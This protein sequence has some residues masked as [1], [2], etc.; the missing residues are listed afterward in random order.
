MGAEWTRSGKKVKEEEKDWNIVLLRKTRWRK[1]GEEE[2]GVMLLNSG[3][4]AVCPGQVCCS[5]KRS[6]TPAPGQWCWRTTV[7]PYVMWGNQARLRP[8]WWSHMAVILFRTAFWPGKKR[9]GFE[10]ENTGIIEYGNGN[11]QR[12]GWDVNPHQWCRRGKLSWREMQLSPSKD[13]EMEPGERRSAVR[14]GLNRESRYSL[15][16]PK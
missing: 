1:Q 8:V 14:A 4:E 6:R 15:T 7:G 2:R 13:G 16:K 10:V 3:R 5:R 9:K 12:M 11:S